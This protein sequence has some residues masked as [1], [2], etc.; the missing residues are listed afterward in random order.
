MKQRSE[1]WD[2][3][4]SQHRHKSG[5]LSF[6]MDLKERQDTNCMIQV[7]LHVQAQTWA[8]DSKITWRQQWEQLTNEATTTLMFCFWEMKEL[9]ISQD[10][11]IQV[12]AEQA[13]GHWH[14]RI[15]LIPAP[16]RRIYHDTWNKPQW[17]RQMK[18]C[19]CR[20]QKEEYTYL[21]FISSDMNHQVT[22]WACKW[23]ILIMN[24]TRLRPC[25]CKHTQC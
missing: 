9:R 4:M 7:A 21:S 6:F 3:T 5:Q 25:P 10:V 1:L 22:L 8:G 12:C 23:H 20:N 18:T 13:E 15:S 19:R 17:S 14:V 24:I 16:M 11:L 2:L